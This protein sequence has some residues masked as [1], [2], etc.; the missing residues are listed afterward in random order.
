[1]YLSSTPGFS[2]LILAPLTTVPSRAHIISSLMLVATILLHSL[3]F[4]AVECPSIA[5]YPAA[6]T[7]MRVLTPHLLSMLRDV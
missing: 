7:L 5:L 6:A 2:P 3:V 1:M 4:N